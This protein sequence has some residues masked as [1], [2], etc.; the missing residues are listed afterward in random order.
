VR[1]VAEAHTL[2][3]GG[4]DAF[5][6]EHGLEGGDILGQEVLVDTPKR[7]RETQELDSSVC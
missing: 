4:G 1:A 2:D 7:C 5:G 6:V 3:H